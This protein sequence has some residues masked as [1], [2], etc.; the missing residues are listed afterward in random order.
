MSVQDLMNIEV[1]SV[2][3]REQKLSDAAAAVF[4]ITREDIRRSGATSIPE[5][6]RM[7][8]G[9]E[10]AH[11]DANKWAISSRGF[12][13]RFANKLLVLMDGR[14]VYTPLYSGVFW[15]VQDTMLEDIDRIEV[16]RGPGATLWGANAVNGVVNI[17]TKSAEDTRG[18]LVVAGS[19]SEERGFGA[20]RYGGRIREDAFWRVYAKSFSR[21]GGVDASDRDGADD[22]DAF[23][24]GF[25]LDWRPTGEDIFTFEGDAYKEDAGQTLR[26]PLLRQPFLAFLDDSAGI[27][28]TDLLAKWEHTFSS[29]SSIGIQLYYDRMKIEDILLTESR[30]TFDIELQ[31]CFRTLERH[32]FIWGLGYRLYR[33][34]VENTFQ[35]ALDPAGKDAHLFS[36]F[37]QDD[38]SLIKEKLHLILGAKIEHNDYT[39]FEIQPNARLIWTPHVRHTL[40]AAVSRAVRTPSRTE[41]DGRLNI[42]VLPPFAPGNPSPNPGIVSVFGNRDFLSEELIA[43]EL[44]YRV[45]P[46]TELSFDLAV[47]YNDY[48]H[49]RTVGECFCGSAFFFSLYQQ[50]GR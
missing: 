2:S 37:L 35:T 33:D 40:W 23:R 13:S 38:I 8:P 5:V 34:S 21:D 17:I 43:Y 28:G 18:G 29:S 25:R 22:W 48:D 1:S 10:V 27:E 41:E 11:I 20:V 26:L 19:G 36:V 14:T 45:H 31:H 42:S 7:A 32:E 16:I 4:V 24:G 9:L 47:F 6:L 12:N 30:D 15:D 44:G 3:R 39:G 46:V 50:H 49:L